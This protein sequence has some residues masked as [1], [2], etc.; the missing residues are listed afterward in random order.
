MSWKV[1]YTL[2]ETPGMPKRIM[3]E[4]LQQGPMTSSLCTVPSQMVRVI[5][6]YAASMCS[7]DSLLDQH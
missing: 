3:W 6:T 7:S 5:Y 4:E 1:E 2:T